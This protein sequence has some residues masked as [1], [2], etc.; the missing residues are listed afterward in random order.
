MDIDDRI[1]LYL[2]AMVLASII[3]IIALVVV[4]TKN[5]EVIYEECTNNNGILI[6]EYG[7]TR[8]YCAEVK[9]IKL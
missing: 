3:T 6:Q 4:T 2:L 9:R 7:S 8:Y 5:N 1:T